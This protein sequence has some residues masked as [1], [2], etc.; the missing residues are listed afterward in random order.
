MFVIPSIIF[1]LNQPKSQCAPLNLEDSKSCPDALTPEC[2]ADVG[3]AKTPGIPLS[4]IRAVWRLAR[5]RPCSCCPVTVCIITTVAGAEPQDCCLLTLAKPNSCGSS[6]GSNYATKDIVDPSPDHDCP[7]LDRGEAHNSLLNGFSTK[8]SPALPPS[9]AYGTRRPELASSGC[10][11]G[12]FTNGSRFGIDFS[13]LISSSVFPHPHV[14]LSPRDLVAL[15]CCLTW[16]GLSKSIKWFW[17]FLNLRGKEVLT[18]IPPQSAVMCWGFW[19]THPLSQQH[20]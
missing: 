4:E 16:V 19:P 11:G 17:F 15:S 10:V 12:T 14:K 1:F 20:Q 13:Q 6:C 2:A 3:L 7:S 18:S 9:N 5:T 8:Y